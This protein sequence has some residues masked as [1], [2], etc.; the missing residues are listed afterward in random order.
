MCALVAHG[1]PRQAFWRMWLVGYAMHVSGAHWLPDVLERFAGHPP[2]LAWSLILLLHAFSA[3]RYG[4]V[5]WIV[6][7]CRGEGRVILLLPVVWT[8]LEFLSPSLFP[9][10]IGHALM[11]VPILVQ[12]VELTGA[13]GPTFLVMWGGGLLYH[14]AARLL[15]A[16]TLAPTGGRT[17]RKPSD[18]GASAPVEL[19]S[20]KG[21]MKWHFAAFVLVVALVVSF[22]AW[23]IRSIERYL[24]D[25]PGLRVAL[26]QS[27]TMGRDRLLACMKLSE[28]LPDDVQLILWPESAIGSLAM[29][30]DD[31]SSAE[32]MEAEDRD[33]QSPLVG[34]RAYYLVGGDS[35][36]LEPERHYNSAM[37]VNP[38]QRIIAR[39]HKRTLIP[40]GEYI[41]GER[42]FPSLRRFSPWEIAFEAGTSAEPLV[43]PGLAKPGIC[44]C[45][46]DVLAGLNRATVAA[47]ADLLVNLT[48]DAWFGESKALAQHQQL[49]SMRTI[50]NRRYLLRSTT[51][52]STAII[53]PTGVTVAQ[54]PLGKPTAL[55]TE[56]QTCDLTTFYTRFGD[57]FAWLCVLGV[58]LIVLRHRLGSRQNRKIA[59]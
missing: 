14:L 40:F 43:V 18:S 54:A 48:N 47:G 24:A 36:Q 30:F 55:V 10:R 26:I 51:T 37:L 22:G 15:L 28:E 17:G 21:P 52:G 5:G 41:P 33:S 31:F 2:A 20:Q 7:R 23:R 32:Q 29:E 1:T 8:A 25:A 16:K 19:P 11:Q 39:Y 3:I 35:Y 44:I 27:G 53:S 42:W 49:A 4:L 34:P 38:E 9:Y 45:Y 58:A 12:F 6:S 59:S 13:Y 50:E 57:V 56:V 46:E